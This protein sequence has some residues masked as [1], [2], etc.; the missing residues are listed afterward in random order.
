[1][2]ASI[3]VQF[4]ADLRAHRGALLSGGDRGQPVHAGSFL[5]RRV[6]VLDSELRS[7]ESEL[8]RILLHEV[9]HF[10]WIRLGNDRRRSYAELI[11]REFTRRSR[12]EMGWSA[13]LRKN[14][15]APEDMPRRTRR[16][17]EYVC[18]SFCDSG[19]AFVGGMSDHAEVTLATAFRERRAK[20]FGI[21]LGASRI[22]I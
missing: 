19:A 14:A 10:S 6:I 4:R 11:G 16:W 5:R 3:D 13:E 15:L 22:P 7:N 20:W 1:M 2:G 9:F 8:R 12:G 17:S 18:E 21:I